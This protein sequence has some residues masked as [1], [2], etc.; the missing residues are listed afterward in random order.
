MGRVLSNFLG[1]F[2]PAALWCAL[3]GGLWLLQERF[4]SYRPVDA[5]EAAELKTSFRNSVSPT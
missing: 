3:A 4:G 5:H 2:I 1:T